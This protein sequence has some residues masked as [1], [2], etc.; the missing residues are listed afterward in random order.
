MGK[1]MTKLS[2]K[3][4]LTVALSAT[5]FASSISAASSHANPFEMTLLNSGY[6]TTL[7]HHQDTM[8][9]DEKCEEGK[10]GEGKCGD[11]KGGE[12]KCGSSQCDTPA[13]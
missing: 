11:S 3:H 10:C 4:L 9:S 7:S 13:E 5:A 12:G 1:I 2:T 6:Q 8:G